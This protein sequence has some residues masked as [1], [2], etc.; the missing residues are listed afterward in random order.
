MSRVVGG[1]AARRSGGVG[2]YAIASITAVLFLAPTLATVVRSFQTSTAALEG[3]GGLAHLT[4]ANY[5]VLGRSGPGLLQYVQNSLI[6]SV[7]TALLSIVLSTLA[8]YAFARVRFAGRGVLFLFVLS[9]FLVPLTAIIAPVYAVA[10]MLQLTN[11]LVGLIL[12][13]TVFQLPFSIFVMRNAFASIPVELEEASVLDG[14][15]TLGMI[16]RTLWPLV[17]P[18]AATVGLYAFLAAWNEFLAALIMLN[19]ESNYTLPIALLNIQSGVF[20]TID[21]GALSAGATIATI[22]CFVLFLLLQ[23][24]YVRGLTAGAVKL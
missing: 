19:S 6:L 16:R 8:G 7:G 24:Y 1:S 4:L 18:G 9:P 15:G 17:L 21:I 10:S 14:L 3:W 5:A 22:P 20:G 11:S 12:V 23:R 2:Y 13:Y